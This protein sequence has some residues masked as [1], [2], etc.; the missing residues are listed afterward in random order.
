MNED[1]AFI[2]AIVDNP[3]DDTHRLVYADWLDDRDDPRGPYLR[4]EMEWVRTGKKVKALRS[5][6]ATLDAVWMYRVSRP[7]V[8]ICFFSDS[9]FEEGTL[10]PQLSLI[11]VES[12]GAQFGG[13][14]HDYTAFLLNY[15]G[16]QL[17]ASLNV[18]GYEVSGFV[19][20]NG[21][22]TFR[23]VLKRLSDDGEYADWGR[24]PFAYQFGYANHHYCH[25][26]MIMRRS[27]GQGRVSRPVYYYDNP[28]A[29]EVYDEDLPAALRQNNDRRV[30]S[31]F[32]AYID[33]MDTFFNS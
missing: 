30:A 16:G 17:T 23:D 25:V 3:G 24:I 22:F 33:E 13:F 21:D 9:V 31:S 2:R 20:I 4:A 12:A 11:D 1:E 27:H 14:P 26:A 7:P 8:G 19:T 32:T 28:W 6:G 5:L 10:G 29:N 15:N 18:G